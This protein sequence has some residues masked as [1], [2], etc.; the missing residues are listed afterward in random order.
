MAASGAP[1]TSDWALEVPIWQ[2][3]LDASAPSR[4]V[5]AVGDAIFQFRG[6]QPG[7]A[8]A[9][10]SKAVFGATSC[11]HCLV[12]QLEGGAPQ[13]LLLAELAVNH[14]RQDGA[15]RLLFGAPLLPSLSCNESRHEDTQA[16]RLSVVSAD[17]ALHTIVYT[18]HATEGRAGGLLRQ[19]S[20]PS[21]ITT[22]PLAPLFQRLGAPSAV[23]E[24]GGWTC[25]GTEEGNIVC[26]PVGTADPAAA[27]VLAP[28][29]GFT[30]VG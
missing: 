28:S 10:K 23:Q 9:G 17:G 8:R 27:V 13:Q 15:A 14:E 25:V 4:E 12:W 3:Q 19:L 7:V 1:L 30:K 29:S 11:S 24:V 6:L 5:P 22:V 16:T 18:S 26:L 2:L 20:A 21:S